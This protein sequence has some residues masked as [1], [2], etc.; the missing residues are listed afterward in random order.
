MSF[1]S[2]LF[3]GAA[4]SPIQA[5]GNTFDAIFTSDEERLQ[6]QAMLQKIA[7]QP[8]I[9]QA[10][11]SKVEAAHRS[12]FVAGWRP[13]I[14]WVAGISLFFFYVPQYIMATIVWVKSIYVLGFASI[15]PFPVSAD[16]LLELVMALLGLG[17]LRT[18]EK[19]QG[20]S[21]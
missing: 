13:W 16:G 21:K 17:V 1:L 14:G 2:K 18:I 12:V 8:H 5:I 11:I 6:A 15:P 10:E 3:G 4:A 20:K 19:S 9:L 7:M